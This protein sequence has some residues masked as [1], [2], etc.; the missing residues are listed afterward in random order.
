MDEH[1]DIKRPCPFCGCDDTDIEEMDHGKFIK[2]YVK[3][4]EC[5]S[6]GPITN[7]SADAVSDWCERPKPDVY[8]VVSPKLDK[9][10]D[11]LSEV[12]DK[13]G[14]IEEAVDDD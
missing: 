12:D 6:T 9:I 7:A 3:C 8:G 13:L 5:E 4:N 1:S 14:E 2:F 11:L 10:K